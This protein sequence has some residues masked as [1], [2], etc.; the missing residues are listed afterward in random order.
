MNQLRQ[1]L[2]VRHRHNWSLLVRFG[3]V[4]ASGVIVNLLA[5]NLVEWIGP[6]YADVWIDLPLTDFNVRW[7]H[8]YVTI[9]FLVANVWNFQLNRSWT[10]QS[11]GHAPWMR[12][13]IAFLLVG[14]LSLIINLMLVTLLLHPHSALSLP[15][16]VFDGTSPLRNRLTWANLIAI[17]IVTPLSFVFNKLWTFSSVRSQTGG[18]GGPRE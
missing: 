16:D 14:M 5:L 12:E 8:L 1:F 15:E 10:F 18:R 17:A 7:Y 4:G 6:Y 3:I 11:G 2:F 9:A 13:Y